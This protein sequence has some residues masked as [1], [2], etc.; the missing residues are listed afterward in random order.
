MH[1]NIFDRLSFFSL[2]LVI[3]LLPIFFLPFTNIP[4]EISK[5]LLLVVGLALSIIF[6][7]IARFFDGKIIIP[8]SAGLL[9]GAGIVLAFLLSAIFSVS[10]QASLFGLMFEVGTFW[11]IFTAFLF[12]F[13]SAVLFQ[14]LKNARITLFG[15]I[16]SSAVVLIF[17][18]VHLFI[19]NILSLGILFDKTSNVLGSWNAF[20]IFAGLSALVS[21]LIV[22]FFQTTKMEKLILQI[23]IILSVFLVAAV[24][25]PLV[26]ELLGISSLIIFIY[27]V[28]LTSNK[29]HAEGG[30][31]EA[32]HHK[33]HFPAFSFSL[34]II[35]LFFFISGQ[36]IGGLLPNRLKL[37]N[38][39]ISPSFSATMS[40]AKSALKKSPFFGVGP[41]KFEEAW[42]MHKPTSLN[43]TQFWDVSF[44]SG[45]GLLPT[46]AVT[47]GSLGILAWVVFL[48]LFLVNG[49]KSMFSSV[50]NGINWETMTF[51]VLSLYLFISSFFYSGGTVLFLLAFIFAGVF[52][53]LSA[54]SSE[55]NITFSFLNDHRK[56]FFSILSILLVI[57]ISVSVSFKFIERFTSVSYFRKVLADSSVP[58]AETDIGK[59]LALYTNDLYLRTY[60]QVYLVKLNTLVK[61]AGPS[62][63]DKAE[64]QATLDQAIN[65]AQAAI[66]YNSKNYLNF[67]MLGVVYQTAGS[68]GVKDAYAK[69]IEPYKTASALNPVNPGIKL[70]LSNIYF[71]NG[72]MKEAKNYANSALTL[73]PDF[74][75]ALINLSQIAKNEGNS[76]EAI[77]FAE[78]ALAFDPTNQYLIKYV[79][80]LKGSNSSSVATPP[81]NN[82][83]GTQKKN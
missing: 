78:Q 69:A 82:T 77:S 19:P 55:K 40:I 70:S 73:K 11:F 27:K 49:V 65:G 64:M 32:K 15:V 25:F 42:V 67:Q 37:S 13:M 29:S 6:W 28:L 34:I 58:S 72:D 57:I 23:L 7:A 52:M 33:V 8:K 22:E 30:E 5:S 71:A 62:E 51:F 66:A 50:E 83:S 39:E 18:A 10:Q 47:T 79:D 74:I 48:F 17:Q 20:G 68:L 61:K 1:T 75:D 63:A 16:I 26:W 2:L 43:F 3:T 44:S 54:S 36:F 60:A 59:A 14:N 81:T 46:F 4:V 45:S 21:L 24:N 53:G 35:S 76:T 80:S 38:T 31:E 9:G 56:S 41:N 12:M